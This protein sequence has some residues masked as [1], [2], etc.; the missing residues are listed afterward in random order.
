M[1][2]FLSTI[3]HLIIII[4]IAWWAHRNLSMS[5]KIF[6]PALAVRLGA[7]IAL[8]LLY[9]YYYPVADTFTYFKDASNLAE[10]ARGSFVSYLRLL[11][12]NHAVEDVGLVMLEPRALFLTKVTSV[13]SLLTFDNYWAISLY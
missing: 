11:F 12:L 7:G 1:I 8:G 3:L 4:G 5:H 13:F 6:W 2:S 10:I 9:T